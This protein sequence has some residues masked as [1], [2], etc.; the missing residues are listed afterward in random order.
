MLPVELPASPFSIPYFNFERT[1]ARPARRWLIK[2]SPALSSE[3]SLRDKRSGQDRSRTGEFF[4]ASR[5][6]YN[7]I[8]CRGKTRAIFHG[9]VRTRDER[10]QWKR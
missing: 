6:A 9:R 3:S 7:E 10:K 5:D 8:R 1:N 2:V 4:V